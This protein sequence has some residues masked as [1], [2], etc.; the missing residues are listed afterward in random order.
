MGKRLYPPDDPTVKSG[1]PR[2]GEIFDGDD[3]RRR[4][5]QGLGTAKAPTPAE[6]AKTTRKAPAPPAA[7]G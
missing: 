1:I 6:K 4:V 2:E 5:G 3:A 7:E